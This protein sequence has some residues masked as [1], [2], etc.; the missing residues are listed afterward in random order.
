MPPALSIVCYQGC[1]LLFD[2]LLIRRDRTSSPMRRLNHRTLQV[3]IITVNTKVAVN[4]HQV[5]CTAWYEFK[6]PRVRS[7]QYVHLVAITYLALIVP[8]ERRSPLS[9]CNIQLSFVLPFR[10]Q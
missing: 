3:T 9:F 1:S 7:V 5:L 6:A 4:A 2:I 10:R 8:S